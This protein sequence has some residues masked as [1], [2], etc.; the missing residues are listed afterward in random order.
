MEEMAVL[1]LNV[2]AI[3]FWTRSPN[4]SL[5]DEGSGKI[6]AMLIRDVG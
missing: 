5:A 4:V 1:V 2:E 6:D 3:C